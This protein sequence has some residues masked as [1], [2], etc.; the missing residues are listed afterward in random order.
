VNADTN[1]A[2]WIALKDT[3]PTIVSRLCEE[4]PADAHIFGGPSGRPW[5]HNILSHRFQDIPDRAGVR[6]AITIDWFRDPWISAMPRAGVDTLLVARMAGTSL[7]T[8]ERVYC[9]FRNRPARTPRPG[10]PGSGRPGVC[11]HGESER[12]ILTGI[13]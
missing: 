6:Q 1:A 4:R 8:V 12:K 11:D 5:N 3:A 9:H 13:G 2:L 10:S 7:A